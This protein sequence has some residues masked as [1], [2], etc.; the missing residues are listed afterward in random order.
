[1]F[2]KSWP[3]NWPQPSKNQMI[4]HSHQSTKS[5]TDDQKQH[6]SIVKKW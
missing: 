3:Q 1:M 2:S 5:K 6:I 4:R